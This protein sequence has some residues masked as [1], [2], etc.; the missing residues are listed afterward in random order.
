MDEVLKHTLASTNS[1]RYQRMMKA[2]FSQK[3]SLIQDLIYDLD[4]YTGQ[5]SPHAILVQQMVHE[6]LKSVFETRRVTVENITSYATH[7]VI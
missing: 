3:V 1:T 7:E 4:V 6:S 5:V 2:M